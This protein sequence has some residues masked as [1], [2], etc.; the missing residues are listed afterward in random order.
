MEKP[1]CHVQ[2]QEGGKAETTNS[3]GGVQMN[4]LKHQELGLKKPCRRVGRKREPRGGMK[5][6]VFGKVG[7]RAVDRTEMQVERKRQ[8]GRTEHC[9][10]ALALM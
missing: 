4:S 10:G 1:S 7:V 3:S 8:D 2:T 5:V 6:E 9:A